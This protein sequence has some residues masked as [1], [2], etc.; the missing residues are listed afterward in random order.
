MQFVGIGDSAQN[1]GMPEFD[2]AVIGAGVFGAWLARTL[3]RRGKRVLLVDQYGPANN[4]A[5]SGGE[6]RI[7]RMGYGAKE[8]YTRWSWRAR[9]LYREFYATTDPTLLQQTGILW[10]AR[11]EDETA[12]ATMATFERCG[13]PYE[14]LPAAEIEARFPQFR[15]EA[16]RGAIWEPDAAGLL[17]R[18]GV[19][20]VVRETVRE[21]L[22]FRQQAYGMPAG[23]AAVYVYACGP[24]LPKVFPEVLGGRIRPTRQEVLY[25]GA[26]AGT[27]EWRAPAMPCWIDS[28]AGL[29]GIPDIEE[30]GFKIA[31]DTHGPE[32]DPD[33]QSRLVD[34]ATV[35]R[36]RAYVARRF[37]ALAE[38]P[39][40]QTEVCQYENTVDG[41]YLID[42]HPEFD[43]VWLLGGGSGHG[44]KHGPVVGEYVA[45]ALLDGAPIDPMFALA[46]KRLYAEGTRKSTI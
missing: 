35:E 20:T 25:F 1:R 22:T 9:E 17:A 39:V 5:S 6:T 33:T 40:T 30:R 28:A 24:W 43:N 26:A 38:A 12:R 18:R 32:V 13:V 7:L 16:E 34:E 4:R 8:I 31:I 3:H 45:A 46:G 15:V 19:Q 29:Y 2:Y 42:R 41:D 23:E 10:L 21:G 14:W 11:R 36:V 27:G 37:P 44:Y